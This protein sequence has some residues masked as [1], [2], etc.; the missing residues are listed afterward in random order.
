L[1]LRVSKFAFAGIA[2]E[3]IAIKGKFTVTRS[4]GKKTLRNR[5]AAILTLFVLLLPVILMMLGFSVDMAYMQMVQAELRLASDNVARVAAENLSRFENEALAIKAGKD[6]AEGF[7]VG[8]KTLRLR[9]EDFDFGR[10]LLNNDGA[11]DFDTNGTPVNAVRVN[12]S[13]NEANPDGPVPLF[14]SRL[15]SNHT[16]APQAAA[17]ASFKNVDI[18][19][20]LDRSSSM[21][22]DVNSAQSGL[23]ITD[24]RF[25]KAPLS[26]SRWTAL[27][28]A[29]K[30]FTQVLRGNTSDEQVSVVTF[31]SDINKI[32]SGLCGRRANATLDLQLSTDL[33]STDSAIDSLSNNVWNGNTEIYS[34]IDSAISELTSNRSRRFAEKVMIVLTDGY[35]TAGDAVA[36][37]RAAAD[38]G[39]VVYA[40]TFGPD[41]DQNHMRDVASAGKGEHAHA[42][43]EETL[44][45]IFKR[46]AAKTT[47]LVQ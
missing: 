12:A 38:K 42:A 39:I 7:T 14:F 31:G 25:C 8:G 41:S 32:R 11:Y 2:E 23:S 15:V 19:L 29:V 9:N 6:V 34:G 40:I 33:N 20:V 22:L 27:D 26:S 21:K 18:C 4:H 44:K 47:L 37:A 17:T 46:F 28:K 35:P 10:A 5:R 1:P 3:K 13:R 16:F 36:S 24:L 43:D 45:E 30:V